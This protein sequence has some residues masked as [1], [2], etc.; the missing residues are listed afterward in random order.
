MLQLQLRLVIHVPTHEIKSPEIELRF[1]ALRALFSAPCV[2]HECCHEE[3]GMARYGFTAHPDTHAQRTVQY[4]T[5][6]T[7]SYAG[8]EPA[9]LISLFSVSTCSSPPISM[10]ML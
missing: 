10:A 1:P 6:S 9:P 7:L 8:L 4:N 5:P 2:H 3:H